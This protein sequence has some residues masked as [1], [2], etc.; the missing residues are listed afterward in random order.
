M[1]SKSSTNHKK[2]QELKDQILSHEEKKSYRSTRFEKL[3]NQVIGSLDKQDTDQA[4]TDIT[5]GALVL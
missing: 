1:E 5:I 4:L 3:Q 2:N